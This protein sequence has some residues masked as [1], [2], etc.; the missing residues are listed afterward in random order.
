M[1]VE[2]KITSENNDCFQNLRITGERLKDMLKN[3]PR[4]LLGIIQQM[5]KEFP[6]S[7]NGSPKGKSNNYDFLIID[8]T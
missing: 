5:E 3:E 8:P 4:T 2:I 6:I 7:R 1:N